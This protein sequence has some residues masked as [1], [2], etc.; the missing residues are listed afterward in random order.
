MGEKKP[1]IIGMQLLQVGCWIGEQYYTSIIESHDESLQ[2]K[3]DSE[4]R[5][6]YRMDKY[7]KNNLKIRSKWLIHNYIQ[8][9]IESHDT[10]LRSE[11]YS[12]SVSL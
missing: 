8:I 9:H 1:D 12:I 5:L 6:V 7:M 10:Y 3:N 11:N 2:S 4:R